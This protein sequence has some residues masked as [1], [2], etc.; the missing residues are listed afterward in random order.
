MANTVNTPEN[1]GMHDCYTN[2]QG[3]LECTCLEQRNSDGSDPDLPV[4]M[5]DTF[6]WM[7]SLATAVLWVFVAGVAGLCAGIIA[8]AWK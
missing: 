4:T 2:Q 8:G 6:D 7:R 5:V 3:R 1:T